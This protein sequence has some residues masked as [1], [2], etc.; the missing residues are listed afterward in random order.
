[1]TPFERDEELYMTISALTKFRLLQA[2]LDTGIGYESVAR[3]ALA[4]IAPIVRNEALR[5]EK[6]LDDLV[7]TEGSP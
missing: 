6:K 3:E 4:T 1:M 7:S 2:I 5:L